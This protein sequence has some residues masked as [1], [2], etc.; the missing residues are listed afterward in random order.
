MK[1]IQNEGKARFKLPGVNEDLDLVTIRVEYKSDTEY[2]WYATTKDGIGSVIILRKGANY[3]GHFSLGDK[4]EFQITSEDGQ[5]MLLRMKTP[6]I[7]TI[8]CDFQPTE[9]D[10]KLIQNIP[11][12]S[13]ERIEQC[14][15]PIRVLVLW[16]QNAENTGWNMNDVVNTCVAQFNS[17]INRSGIFGAGLTLAGSQRVNFTEGNFFSDWNRLASD[18]VIQNLRN[19]IN[20]NADIV[21]LLTNGNYGDYQGTVG[22]FSMNPNSAYAVVQVGNA[23]GE[24]KVFAHEVGHLFDARHK[25]DN[26]DNPQPYAHSHEIVTPWYSSNCNTIMHFSN[27]NR[28]ENFSNPNV[29]VSGIATGVA[30]TNDNARRIYETYQTVKNHRPP[31]QGVLSSSIDGITYC[32]L[33]RTYTWEAVAN[34][35]QGAINYEWF[36]SSDGFNWNF[37]GSGEFYSELFSS[38]GNNNYRFLRLR[39]TDAVGQVGESFITIY[40]HQDGQP[41]RIASSGN[42]NP[43]SLVPPIVWKNPKYEDNTS[44]KFTLTIEKIYPNPI[45]SSFIL[46]F[47]TSIEQDM[48]LDV[49]DATGH[50][51][52]LFAKEHYPKGKYAKNLSVDNLASGIYV[53]KL[54]SDIESTTKKLVILK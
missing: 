4:R 6:K 27:D 17:C 40:L 54:S 32:E 48:S 20:I 38:I 5:H 35:P 19:N 36:T 7:G 29:S 45:Q 28:I 52:N 22:N 33:F 1:K 23:V 53:V 25:I 13:S 24:D 10:K 12:N 49:N 2:N 18:G 9:K 51:V 43:V 42:E 15:D 44:E 34:C 46:S 21:V 41:Y 39:V 31:I 14:G 50:T 3:T 47:S 37:S 8:F 16:T 11:K 26:I 30:N